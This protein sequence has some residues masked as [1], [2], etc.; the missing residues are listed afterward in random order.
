MTPETLR[1]LLL[2]RMEHSEPDARS[3]YAITG[4]APMWIIATG[5]DGLGLAARPAKTYVRRNMR[6]EEADGVS[7]QY[8][9]EGEWIGQGITGEWRHLADEISNMLA[10]DGKLVDVTAPDAIEEPAS[11][12]TF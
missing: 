4:H 3:P 10:Q 11:G 12:P 1:E 8:L 2:A 5:P 6:L 9:R 7:Y